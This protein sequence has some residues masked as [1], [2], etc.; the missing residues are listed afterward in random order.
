[1]LWRL[2]GVAGQT[3]EWFRKLAV[4]H[5]YTNAAVIE[6]RAPRFGRPSFGR[7]CFGTWAQQFFWE[8]H[9][10]ERLVGGARFG[11][12][13]FGERFGGNPNNAIECL[14]QRWMPAHTVVDFSYD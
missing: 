9:L 12:T 8:L 10:G 14:V 3:P 5:G 11:I 1:V 7:D 13:H 4:Q 6:Y 2:V